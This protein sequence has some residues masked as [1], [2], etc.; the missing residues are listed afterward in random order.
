M[1]ILKLIHLFR[2]KIDKLT[3]KNNQMSP[4]L[5][6]QFP[7]PLLVSHKRV[8]KL[9]QHYVTP[10]FFFFFFFSL[11]GETQSFVF[12]IDRLYVEIFSKPTRI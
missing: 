12:I 11:N 9:R 6:G 7:I 2:K 4:V 10:F 3:N 5:E 1:N 8:N